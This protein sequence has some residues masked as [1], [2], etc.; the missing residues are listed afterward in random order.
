MYITLK[1]EGESEK[2]LI[3][4]GGLIELF[5]YAHC[6]EVKTKYTLIDGRRCGF[7]EFKINVAS[8]PKA[9]LYFLQS[10]DVVYLDMEEDK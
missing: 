10:D 4:D 8:T 9:L 1:I 2:D 7:T 3:T 6:E 5:T